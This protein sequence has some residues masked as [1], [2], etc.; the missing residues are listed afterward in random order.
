MAEKAIQVGEKFLD[1]K[2]DSTVYV[3]RKGMASGKDLAVAVSKK[4]KT[5]KLATVMVNRNAVRPRFIPV[6]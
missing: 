3:V 1:P 2:N 6:K 5:G 4:K